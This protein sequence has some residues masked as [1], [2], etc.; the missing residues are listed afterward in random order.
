MAELKF[1]TLYD[2][3]S[4]ANQDFYDDYFQQNYDPNKQWTNQSN[5]LKMKSLPD[6]S[7][8]DFNAMQNAYN[9][10]AQSKTANKFNWGSLLGMSSADAAIPTDAETAAIERSGINTLPAAQGPWTMFN[11]GNRPVNDMGYYGDSEYTGG[12]SGEVPQ[13]GPGRLDAGR[14]NEPPSQL[15]SMRLEGEPYFAEDFTLKDILDRDTTMGGYQ[16]FP[17]GDQWRNKDKYLRSEDYLSTL[18]PSL[19]GTNYDRKGFKLPGFLGAG[20]GAIRDMIPNPL[21]KGSSNYNPRLEGQMADLKARN[22][23][24]DVKWSEYPGY[25]AG[26]ITGGPLAGQNL[27]S[28]FGTNDYNE[29]LQKRID[30]FNR[31]KEKKGKLTDEQD[32]RL[33]VTIAELQTAGGGG[34]PQGP[35]ITGGGGYQGPPTSSWNPNISGPPTHIGAGPLHGAGPTGY[36]GGNRSPGHPSRRARGGRVGYKTGGRV[37]IL[38]AF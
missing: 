18:E 5:F 2:Q 15:R 24:G 26:K 9:Q 1:N 8:P 4:G 27:V 36:T 29:M 14:Y 10:A 38:A 31:Q 11:Q 33:Q 20:L 37:G 22:M 17:Q 23:L 32:R 30:Y 12:L 19:A 34:V 6:Q 35:A 28:G 21:R 7:T 25:G 13:I 16:K 3:M